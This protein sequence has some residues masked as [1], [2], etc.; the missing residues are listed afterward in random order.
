MRRFANLAVGLLVGLG[1]IA[2]LRAISARQSTTAPPS[3]APSSAVGIAKVVATPTPQRKTTERV[4]SNQPIASLED[5]LKNQDPGADWK[6][7]R[8][9][10]G[11]TF[12]I[13]G[14]KI[15]I[16]QGADGLQELLQ[17]LTPFLIGQTPE[18]VSSTT[19]VGGPVA[20][21][22]TFDQRAAGYRVYGAFVRASVLKGSDE[23]IEISSD[24]RAVT[25]VDTQIALSLPQAEVGVRAKYQGLA[26]LRIENEPL[27][28]G[29]TPSENEMTWKFFVTFEKPKYVTREVLISAR[30]GRVVRDRQISK[31]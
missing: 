14:G 21:I 23:V 2:G 9:S 12:G 7:H 5:F 28:Y 6:I 18:L 29:T 25:N 16:P 31:R 3:E 4:P 26:R 24:L 30:D 22:Q 27:V 13:M 10:E 17:S 15:K 20:D 1:I 19:A 11:R 8:T